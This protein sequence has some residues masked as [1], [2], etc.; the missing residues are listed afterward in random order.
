MLAEKA[1]QKAAASGTPSADAATASS[2]VTASTKAGA[3]MSLNAKS[4]GAIS[5]IVLVA[6]AMFML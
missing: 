1:A 5:T 2:P 6:V 3:A 4:G